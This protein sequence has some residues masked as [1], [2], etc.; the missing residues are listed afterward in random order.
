MFSKKNVWHQRITF[1]D[2][3]RHR[4]R[5]TNPLMGRRNMIWSRKTL[6]R[7]L[8]ALHV[9]TENCTISNSRDCTCLQRESWMRNVRRYLH[10]MCQ[11]VHACALNKVHYPR[12]R[13]W[14]APQICLTYENEN[15]VDPKTKHVSYGFE[16]IFM[17]ACDLN[18]SANHR[19]R[20][21][22]RN[23]SKKTFQLF[24]G[25]NGSSD[26]SR[27]LVSRSWSRKFRLQR[28][29]LQHKRY[30]NVQLWYYTCI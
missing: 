28:W 23:I 12:D 17:S 24:V 10:Q 18:L 7:T 3:K 20:I 13:E 1:T 25:W 21:F 4:K 27:L 8:Q 26:F 5:L 30:R 15:Q 19:F 6:V 29:C 14:V 9:S 2:E 22:K 16:R 11:H